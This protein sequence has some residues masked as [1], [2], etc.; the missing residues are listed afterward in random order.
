V[1]PRLKF[2]R[3]NDGSIDSPAPYQVLARAGFHFENHE[4]PLV[5]HQARG[6]LNGSSFWHRFQMVHFD[7]RANGNR[8]CGQVRLNACA[9]AISII[10]IIAGVESTGGNCGL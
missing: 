8:S 5:L 2:R 10:P 4:A 3:F 9:A 1:G 6:R 7:P